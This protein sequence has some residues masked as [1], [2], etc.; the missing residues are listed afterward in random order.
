MCIRDKRRAVEQVDAAVVG[1]ATGRFDRLDGAQGGF[2]AFHGHDLLVDLGRSDLFAVGLGR[3]DEMLLAVSYTHLDTD[4]DG[5]TGAYRLYQRFGFVP[6]R[7]EDVYEK[8][9]RP[10]VEWRVMSADELAP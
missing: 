4:S 10:G 9:I 5:F 3:G 2:V 8:E 1:P 7:F 6:Y